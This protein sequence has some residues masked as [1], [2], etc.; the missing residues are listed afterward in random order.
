MEELRVWSSSSKGSSSLQFWN[1]RLHFPP[2]PGAEGITAPA[3]GAAG[4]TGSGNTEAWTYPDSPDSWCFQGIPVLLILPCPFK[5]WPS[6][7]GRFPLLLVSSG[8][9]NSACQGCRNLLF[10]FLESVSQCQVNIGSTGLDAGR[11]GSALWG[12]RMGGRSQPRTLGQGGPCPWMCWELFPPLMESSCTLALPHAMYSPFLCGLD[13]FQ[14]SCEPKW[15][16]HLLSLMPGEV[17]ERNCSL[18]LL[19]STFHPFLLEIKLFIPAVPSPGTFLSL[20][21]FAFVA[22]IFLVTGKVRQG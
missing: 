9:D 2:S 14:G 6:L 15:P 3:A 12:G 21:H 17:R 20:S 18:P 4:D 5:Q 7:L 19:T 11:M 8:R 13:A 1:A 16:P 22:F 10:I